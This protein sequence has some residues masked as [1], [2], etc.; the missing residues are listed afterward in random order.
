MPYVETNLVL[1][2]VIAN[3]AQ[4]NKIDD[5]SDSFQLSLL[6]SHAGR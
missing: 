3:Y 6:I 4:I 2:S 5:F 1:P